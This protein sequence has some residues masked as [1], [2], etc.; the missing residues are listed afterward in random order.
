MAA[1]GGVGSSD[2]RI[3][4]FAS[5]QIP[6]ASRSIEMIT[7]AAL[8]QKVAVISPDTSLPVVRLNFARFSLETDAIGTTIDLRA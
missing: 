8:G 6:I 5:E 1:I 7:R 4:H 2:P 3:F